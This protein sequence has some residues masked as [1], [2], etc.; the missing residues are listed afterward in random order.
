MFK[1]T[2]FVVCM[3]TASCMAS[4]EVIQDKT[5]LMIQKAVSKAD[6]LGIKISVAVVDAHGN[7]KAFK[8]MDGAVLA[9][10]KLSQAKAYT[11]ASVPVSTGDLAEMNA[12]TPGHVFGNIPG[13]VLLKGGV[14]II[15][16]AGEPSGAIGV[17][18]GSG[19]Q[20]EQCAF[21]AIH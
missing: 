18:G 6:E 11:S 9:S 21:A 17:G 14:P 10:L 20:D 4:Q 2:L 13:F 5:D 8:R 15:S 19:E 3:M 16:E 12:K 1:K 7:L